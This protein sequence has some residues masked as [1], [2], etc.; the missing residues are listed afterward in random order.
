MLHK[1]ATSERALFSKRGRP[2]WNGMEFN[3][4]ALVLACRKGDESAWETLIRRYQRLIYSIPRRA[5][6]DESASSDVFQNVFA[7]LVE[8]LERIE[9]PERIHAWLVT[10]SRRETWRFILRNRNSVSI[11]T[12]DEPGRIQAN[13]IADVAPLQDEVLLRLESQTQI[14]S[15]IA[16]LDERCRKLINLLFYGT[17]PASYSEIAAE[18]SAPEGSIGPTRARCLQKL[19]KLLQ[20]MGL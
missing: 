3:D 12:E 5:G 15:A 16:S 18:L 19:L 14:R 8:N 1:N 17:D 10:T 7:I 11:S 4:K 13:E 20:E 9:Q 2:N 6:L